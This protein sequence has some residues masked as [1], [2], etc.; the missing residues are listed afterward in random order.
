MIKDLRAG[1][2]RSRLVYTTPETLCGPAFTKTLLT[3]YEQGELNR[4]VIDEAH[5]IS[6]WGQFTS[7]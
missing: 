7:I 6:E 4:L 1:H 3:I 2:P 5:C